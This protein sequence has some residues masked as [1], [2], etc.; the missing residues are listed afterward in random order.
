MPSPPTIRRPCPEGAGPAA[1]PVLAHCDVCELDVL[2]LSALSAEG[3]ER[4]LAESPT[5]LCVRYRVHSATG[6]TWHRPVRRRGRAGAVTLALGFGIG[7]VVLATLA[8]A[9]LTGEAFAEDAPAAAADAGTP[10]PADAGAPLTDAPCV[11]PEEGPSVLPGG[12]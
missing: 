9:E 6:Q 7:G 12:L 1:G 10:P 3:A 11:P 2:D 4:V 8:L 5:G